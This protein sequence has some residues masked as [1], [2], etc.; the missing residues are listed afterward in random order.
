M[1]DWK[2]AGSR[3][4]PFNAVLQESGPSHPLHSV[5]ARDQSRSF[6]ADIMDVRWCRNLSL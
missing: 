1:I 4:F 6:P 2:S 5:A 3:L